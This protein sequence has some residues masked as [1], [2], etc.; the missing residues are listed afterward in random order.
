MLPFENGA[1]D[2]AISTFGV[3]F[4]LYQVQAAAELSRVC[5]ARGRLVLTTWAPAEAAHCLHT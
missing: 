4:A 3:A 1:F 2:G 5:R